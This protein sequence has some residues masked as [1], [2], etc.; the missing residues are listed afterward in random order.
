M[1]PLVDQQ[2][3]GLLL[4]VVGDMMSI[5]AAGVVMAMWWRKEEEQ[6]QIKAASP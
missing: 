4:W 1:S 3:G 2:L 6:E 5:L